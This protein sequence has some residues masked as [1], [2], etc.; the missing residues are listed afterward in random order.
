MDSKY[1]LAGLGPSL[2]ERLMANGGRPGGF[3]I[4]R[5]REVLDRINGIFR[6]GLCSMMMTNVCCEYEWVQ[7]AK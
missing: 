6:I 5:G 2:T 1:D 3:V 7:C 4:E